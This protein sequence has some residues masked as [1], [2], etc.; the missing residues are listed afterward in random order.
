MKIW[1][2]HYIL[3]TRGYKHKHTHTHPEY[4]IFITLHSNNVYTKVP[5]CYFICKLPFLILT[6]CRMFCFDVSDTRAAS[7]FTVADIS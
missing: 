1:R 6:P 2:F 5:Q 4:V 7:I 3:D